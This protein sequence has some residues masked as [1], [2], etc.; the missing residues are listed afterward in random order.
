[1][2]AGP[3]DS[4]PAHRFENIHVGRDFVIRHGNDGTVVAAARR[5][6]VWRKGEVAPSSIL[7]S[8][9]RVA[10]FVGRAAELDGLIGWCLDENP[11]VNPLRL[12]FGPGGMGK[13][14][15]LLEACERLRGKQGWMA[16]FLENRSSAWPGEAMRELVELDQPKLLVLDYAETRVDDGA[17]LLQLI[18]ARPKG[19]SAVRVVLLARDGPGDAGATDRGPAG[20]VPWIAELRRRSAAAQAMAGALA[21]FALRPLSDDEPVRREAFLT[22]RQRFAEQIHGPNAA[23]KLAGAAEP[24]DL[25]APDFVRVLLIHAAALAS[26]DGKRLEG[27]SALLDYLVDREERA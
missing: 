18:S 12:Y 14:R 19:C 11:E 17:L 13:T 15:F 6:W 22:A 3:Q 2:R 7:D 4:G 10:P 21:S 25:A 20:D 23:G 1:M 9:Y 26:L 27:T 16:G 24:P 8:R 5:E